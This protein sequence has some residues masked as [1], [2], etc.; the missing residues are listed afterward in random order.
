MQADERVRV[1]P[2]AGRTVP[3]VHKD[4]VSVA[5]LDQRIGER[6]PRRPRPD[7]QIVGIHTHVVPGTRGAMRIKVSPQICTG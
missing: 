7:Y 3:P 4:H 5:S 6:Q 2:V 1:V